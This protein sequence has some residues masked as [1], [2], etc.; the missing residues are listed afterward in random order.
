MKAIRIISLVLSSLLILFMA[1]AIF[2]PS[3][4]KIE[5][6]IEIDRP[7]EEVYPY[8]A[9]YA[10]W[11]AWNPWSEREPG[12]INTFSEPS[13]GEGAHW[14][15]EGEEIG[16]GSLTVLQMKENEFL[17]SKISFIEPWENEA[18]DSWKFTAI[19]EQQ[20]KVSW[21][22]EMEL[23]NMLERYYVIFLDMIL[24]EQMEKGLEK[25]KQVAEEE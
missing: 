22:N 7:V 4:I 21:T 2:L 24:G 23:D 16:K 8:V 25:L 13:M 11:P 12:A 3:T 6:S 5:R 19:D 9:D 10:N 20:T 18:K 17:Q 1:G 14:E 15:W